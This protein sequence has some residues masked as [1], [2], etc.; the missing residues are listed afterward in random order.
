MEAQEIVFVNRSLQYGMPAVRGQISDGS[1]LESVVDALRDSPANGA[2]CWL[3]QDIISSLNCTPERAEKVIAWL[4]EG[5]NPS[6]LPTQN[7]PDLATSVQARFDKLVAEEKEKASQASNPNRARARVVFGFD[8]AMRYLTDHQPHGK[9]LESIEAQREILNTTELGCLALRI[10]RRKVNELGKLTDWNV[11]AMLDITE[12]RYEKRELI[13]GIH[14]FTISLDAFRKR[15][16]DT[17]LSPRF[18]VRKHQMQDEAAA[19]KEMARV[20]HAENRA[21]YL[22][23]KYGTRHHAILER[24]MK[25]M[26]TKP[27][28]LNVAVQPFLKG[29]RPLGTL[30]GKDL[31]KLHRF[32]AGRSK[33]TQIHTLNLVLRFRS[34][35]FRLLQ[36]QEHGKRQ[37]NALRQR[38]LAQK[39]LYLRRHMFRAVTGMGSLTRF[40]PTHY[41]HGSE[42]EQVLHQLAW[43][44]MGFL[45]KR[46]LM[47]ILSNAEI[48]QIR[49]QR[50][51]EA[52]AQRPGLPDHR[53]ILAAFIPGAIEKLGTAGPYQ[54]RKAYERNFKRPVAQETVRK[55]CD[56]LVKKGLLR[57]KVAF[58]NLK[59]VKAGR[60]RRRIRRVTYSLLKYQPSRKERR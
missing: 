24:E 48:Q 22:D 55:Y 21:A 11:A 37:A 34:S 53:N 54:L 45:L 19:E 38:V 8:L 7:G 5:L 28:G 16:V 26:P 50:P 6:E 44:Q 9:G 58:D 46:D 43:S 31:A 36:L 59:K 15:L 40:K 2:P 4:R 10:A 12:Q 1:E 29:Q 39:T 60:V 30:T 57:R 52:D 33:A 23:R 20:K 42:L 14:A 49:K 51:T 18:L 56:L 27:N 25:A 32:P 3:K 17:G 41:Q 13:C 35:L 47:P